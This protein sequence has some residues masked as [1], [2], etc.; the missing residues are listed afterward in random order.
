VQA[1]ALHFNAA[2][3]GE[4][5]AECQLD[6]GGLLPEVFDTGWCYRAGQMTVP[7]RPGLGVEVNADLLAS[8]CDRVE[9]WP[10]GNR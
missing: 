5:L 8:H 2:V 1:A 9:R 3:A 10:A 6:L 4:R 7:Q